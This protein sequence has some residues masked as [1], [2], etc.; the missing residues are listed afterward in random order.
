MHPAAESGDGTGGIIPYKNPHALIAYYLGYPALF[1]IIGIP[2]GI[3]AI[4][5][6][7]MGLSKRKKNPIIKG[8][9][10]AWFGIICGFTSF[11]CPFLM[12]G[13]AMFFGTL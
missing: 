7:F 11:L 4:I 9:A 13:A 1:P 6:G 5:L 12:F 10:H 8:T 3:A 2:F